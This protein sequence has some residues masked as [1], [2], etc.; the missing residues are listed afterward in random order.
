MRNFN[1]S[2]VG[3]VCASISR[4]FQDDKDLMADLTF[5]VQEYM[6]SMGIVDDYDMGDEA[7]IEGTP[8]NTAW[9]DDVMNRA[10]ELI[11]RAFDKIERL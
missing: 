5:E 3:E 9:E 7:S 11:K 2:D 6:I 10:D 1:N 8:Q 4:M